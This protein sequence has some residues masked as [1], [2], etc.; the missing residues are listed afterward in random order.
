M[1]FT[2]WLNSLFKPKPKPVVVPPIQPPDPP[3]EVRIKAD[4][5]GQ[6]IAPTKGTLKLDWNALELAGVVKNN[7]ELVFTMPTAAPYGWGAQLRV[8]YGAD[9]KSTDQRI[10]VYP[11]VNV[12]V[13]KKPTIKPLQINGAFFNETIIEASSFKLLKRFLDNE[14]IAPVMDELVGLG[15]N[16]VR[17]FGMCRLMWDLNPAAYVNFYSRLADFV[18]YAGSHGLYIEFVVFPDCALVIP[19]TNDQLNHYAGVFQALKNKTNVLLELQNEADQT[20]NAIDIQRFSRPGG[21]IACHGSNGSQASP[22]RPW[23][24]YETFHTNDASEW[25]RKDSHN[26]ME[27]SEGADQITASHVPVLSNENTRFPDH[28]AN[29][30]HYYDAAAA[31]ALLCAGSCF[32]YVNGKE[33]SPMTA[34]EQAGGKAHCDGAKSVDLSQRVFPYQH[35]AELEGPADLRVYSR[36]SAVVRI[37]K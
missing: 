23:W 15:F 16:T 29:V 36:G 31:S 8:E 12:S 10:V 1:S 14:N 13:E 2:E 26:A 33:S 19:N 24:S 17:V 28:D 22:I 3:K 5:R 6:A 34:Q 20:P 4:F 21:M 9:Y 32:H 25:W 30:N 11:D 27:F 35:R 18:D 37:R 7:T